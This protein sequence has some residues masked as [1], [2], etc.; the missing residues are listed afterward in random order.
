MVEYNPEVVMK[1][2]AC[3]WASFF[4]IFQVGIGLVH[5]QSVAFDDTIRVPQRLIQRR[6]P[7][8]RNMRMLD[9]LKVLYPDTRVVYDDRAG[10]GNFVRD[11]QIV[12]GPFV[13][14]DDSGGTRPGPGSIAVLVV[15]QQ[16][17]D[18]NEN[19]VDLLPKL[20]VVGTTHARPI[21]LASMELTDYMVTIDPEH[22]GG[23][24]LKLDSWN[25][26]PSAKAI[27]VTI[28]RSEAG[29]EMNN[30]TAELSLYFVIDGSLAEVYQTDVLDQTDEKQDESM[31]SEQMRV[32]TSVNDSD[33]FNGLRTLDVE[34]YYSRSENGKLKHVEIDYRRLCWN[35]DAFDEY[36]DSPIQKSHIVKVP[37]KIPSFRKRK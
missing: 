8:M 2:S 5:A 17:D 36:C 10:D 26:H 22:D 12:G 20:A 18:D 13:F 25:I 35:G 30:A 21:P 29:P 24:G 3:F 23:S 7:A 15:E 33:I 31:Y 16:G 1:L 14:M 32:K 34:N 11:I 4:L 19:E 28:L 9:I 37:N 27:A 6:V